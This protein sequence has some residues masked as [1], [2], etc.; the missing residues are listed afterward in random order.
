M[1]LFH[2]QGLVLVLLLVYFL[3]RRL[4]IL[5]GKNFTTFEMLKIPKTVVVFDLFTVR[6]QNTF[7]LRYKSICPI[8]S[9]CF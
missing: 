7:F 5:S 4:I 6:K 2:L 9:V 8:V 3:V 1:L